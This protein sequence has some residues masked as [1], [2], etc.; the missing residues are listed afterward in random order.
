MGTT[1]GP[2]SAT[3]E[4]SHGSPC[5]PVRGGVGYSLDSD[6]GS[7]YARSK[8]QRAA[9]GEFWRGNTA[10]IGAR[11]GRHGD[12]GSRRQ[13][14]P[15]RRWP[16]V[17]DAR[18]IH[19]RQRRRAASGGSGGRAIRAST[20]CEFRRGTSTP[21]SGYGMELI[22]GS[23]EQVLA[24]QTQPPSRRGRVL[25]Q[26]VHISFPGARARHRLA[27]SSLPPVVR[28]RSDGRRWSRCS[29]RHFSR[30]EPRTSMPSSA[31]LTAP[32]AIMGSTLYMSPRICANE[33]VDAS[34]TWALG[35]MCTS[36]STGRPPRQRR[37]PAGICPPSPPRSAAAATLAKM[38]KRDRD[39]AHEVLRRASTSA[40]NAKRSW[41][42][43]APSRRTPGGSEPISVNRALTIIEAGSVPPERRA[44]QDVRRRGS[45]ASRARPPR[46]RPSRAQRQSLEIDS[47]HAR[48]AKRKGATSWIVD[49]HVCG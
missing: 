34:T 6:A 3:N 5:R 25:L 11:R 28:T 13:I 46:S 10:S 48:A 12:R 44:A 41:R 24:S 8:E 47:T 36:F 20:S 19:P 2:R 9:A 32:S 21:V 35:V 17:D 40:T 14:D 37:Y 18:V 30:R 23:S 27:I 29:T 26:G 1:T 31:N 42:P 7:G 33:A 15:A 22:R 43:C 45:F 16:Q 39:G 4:P 38:P 49:G